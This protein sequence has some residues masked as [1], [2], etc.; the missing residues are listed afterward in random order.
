M[1]FAAQL[2]K[3]FVFIHTFI[4][5]NGRISRLLINATLIQD[6]LPGCHF[7]DLAPGIY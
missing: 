7:S 4:D 1:E 3:R 6:G 2:H 5:G